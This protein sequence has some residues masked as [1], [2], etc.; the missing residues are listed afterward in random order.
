MAGSTD[1]CA[2]WFTAGA[3]AVA[4]ELHTDPAVGLNPAR[5]RELLQ[6]YGPNPAPTAWQIAVGQSRV[7]AP[8]SGVAPRLGWSTRNPVL[9][10]TP[11]GG[12]CRCIAIPDAVGHGCA[13][14]EV[15]RGGARV[16]HPV[17]GFH[18]G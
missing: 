11:S 6:R 3:E 14:R 15:V 18:T 5:A 8:S 1:I 10:R 16:L 13:T 12:F 7:C 2:Q 17:R 4:A 9:L